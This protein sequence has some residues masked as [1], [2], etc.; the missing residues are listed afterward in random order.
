MADKGK[1]SS[2]NVGE[3]R[4]T[5]EYAHGGIIRPQ[6]KITVTGPTG[7]VETKY[8]P[9]KSDGQDEAKVVGD[10]IKKTQG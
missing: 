1:G 6:D 9:S 8:I 10:L 2:Y 5:R 3:H 4:V 7:K